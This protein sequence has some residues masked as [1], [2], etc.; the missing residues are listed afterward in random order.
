MSTMVYSRVVPLV[1][2]FAIFIFARP[3]FRVFLEVLDHIRSVQ[4]YNRFLVYLSIYRPIEIS[5]LNAPTR[6]I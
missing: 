5:N 6:G 3:D 2:F 1:V 4:N